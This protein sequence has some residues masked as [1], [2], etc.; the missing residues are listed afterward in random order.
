MNSNYLKD[1]QAKQNKI[2]A[3]TEAEEQRLISFA[4]KDIVNLFQTVGQRVDQY[5]EQ[6][7][8]DVKAL[9]L[10][11]TGQSC[12]AMI[13]NYNL[14][15]ELSGKELTIKWFEKGCKPEAHQYYALEKPTNTG[16]IYSWWGSATKDKDCQSKGLADI[17]F[18]KLVSI[19]R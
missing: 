19:T 13:G 16:F 1:K 14:T 5:N 9:L 10:A 3:A 7:N 15:C 2:Q 12:A 8:R 6:A 11:G 18:D 4:Q 17:A